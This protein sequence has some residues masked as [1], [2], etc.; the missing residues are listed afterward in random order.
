M[1]KEKNG[2]FRFKRVLSY[3]EGEGPAIFHSKGPIG[4]TRIV[5]FEA[6]YR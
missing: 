3:G 1:G 5:Y 2:L 6:R 4:Q